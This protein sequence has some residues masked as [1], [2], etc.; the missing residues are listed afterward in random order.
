MTDSRDVWPFVLDPH[1]VTPFRQMDGSAVFSGA[2]LFAPRTPSAC[3]ATK[4]KHAAAAEIPAGKNPPDGA[5]LNYVLAQA[6]GKTPLIFHLVVDFQ[7][8]SPVE[9]PQNIIQNCAIGGFFPAGISAAAACFDSRRGARGWRFARKEMRAGKH[10][11]PIHLAKRR[12]IVEDPERTAIR[13]GYQVIL[14]DGQV[15]DG[16]HWHVQPERLPMISAV[17]RNVNPCWS[18]RTATLAHGILAH[19]PHKIAVANAVDR[20]CQVF[21][22]S[23]VRKMCG[24][25]SSRPFRLTAAYAVPASKCDASMRLTVLHSIPRG[26]MFCHV[27]RRPSSAGCS[28]HP[29]QPRSRLP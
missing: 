18:P 3:A 19:R 24:R 28:H 25:K 20:F 8:K 23:R 27:L 22:K 16:Y 26:V 1:D 17:E 12:D 14:F 7:L 21:P 2:H 29:F 11:A 10:C 4:S 6:P 9:S 5:I 13:R 15:M